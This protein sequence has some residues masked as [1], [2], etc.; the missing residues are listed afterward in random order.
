[1]TDLMTVRVPTWGDKPDWV[2]AAPFRAHV[3]Q[4]M[5]VAQVPWQVI[6]YRAGVPLATL[7]TLLFGRHGKVRTKIT[8]ESAEQLIGLGADDLAWMRQS[9]ISAEKASTRI[10][11]LRSRQIPW[12][13]IAELLTLDKDTCQ[14]IARGERTSCSVMVDIL[15]QSA[16]DSFGLDPWDTDD[17]EAIIAPEPDSADPES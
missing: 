1:M 17:P 4:L 2:L 8:Q 6:A 14:A 11:L 15:A 9:Q 3:A 16:C 13:Q 7:R 5:E 12:P 10:R